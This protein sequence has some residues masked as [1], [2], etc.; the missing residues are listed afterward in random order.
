M[1]I[2]KGYLS[3][4]PWL[5]SLLLFIA[6]A[7]WLGLDWGKADISASASVDNSSSQA[8]LAKV[9]YQTF[10]S[11]NT[12]KTIELYGRTAPDRQA[13]LAAEVA[14]KVMALDVIKGSRVQKGQA[15]AHIDPADLEL[16][17]QRARAALEV[18]EKSSKRQNL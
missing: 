15:I 13:R 1:M 9:V 5:I 18:R 2:L 14:G 11:L 4:R 10:H 12:A 6:I 16:Q 3:R 17:L 8:P 7:L